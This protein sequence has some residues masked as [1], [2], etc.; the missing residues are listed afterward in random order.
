NRRI[1]R[2][3]PDGI[4]RTIAGGGTVM[5]LNGPVAALDASLPQIFSLVLDALDSVYFTTFSAM[6]K[7]GTDGN[8]SPVALGPGTSV[9]DDL[10]VDGAGNLYFSQV[11]RSQVIRRSPDGTLTTFAGVLATGFG[12]DGGPALG[13]LLYLT[14]STATD[15]NGNLYFGD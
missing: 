3:D 15:R 10:T 6:Y 7:L 14:A 1:R 12:G 13:A 2:V 8:I 9:L 4:I 5:N 11:D